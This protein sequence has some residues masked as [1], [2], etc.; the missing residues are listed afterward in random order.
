[1]PVAADPTSASSSS[2][3]ATEPTGVPGLGSPDPFCAAWAGYAGTLQALGIAASFGNLS[4]QRFAALELAAAPRLVELAAAIDSSWPPQPPQLAAERSTVVEA[5]I[6][7]HARRAQH[8][9]DALR[10]AGV[11]AD[12]LSALGEAWQ[13]ALTER[14]P[15][16]P[17]IELPDVAAELQAKIDAAARAYDRAVTPYASDPSLLIRGV[18]S[19]QTDAYL[20][21]HC[22]ELATSGV[23][24][25]L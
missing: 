19:P 13:T 8:A 17:V 23:G 12:E 7:P 9:V 1:V 20:A 22:P 25:S 11:S 24:D 18:E 14:D 2:V 6:G 3:M 4:S 5:R 15:D 10:D 16:E 21:G